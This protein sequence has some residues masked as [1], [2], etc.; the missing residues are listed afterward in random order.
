M[1]LLRQVMPRFPHKGSVRMRTLGI[2]LGKV[3]I[4]V[5]VSD[6]GGLIASPIDVIPA[7]GHKKDAAAV[8]GLGVRLGAQE[9]VV[10]MP[11]R[12]DGT[13][14]HAAES[15][16]R[17]MDELRKLVDVEVVAW[18]E[19]LTSAQANKLMISA[20]ASRRARK[21]AVDSMAAAIMLQ[22]Y[23]DR[24]RHAKAIDVGQQ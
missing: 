14:G 2:D 11:I 9:I 5:A 20:D 18:D 4:G 3:R 10:G 19:R 8:A 23:L 17:F 21:G 12:M 16:G 1:R 15:A 6:P 24:A 7:Q 13:G 22:S